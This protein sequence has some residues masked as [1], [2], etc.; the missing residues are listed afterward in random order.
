MK[1]EDTNNAKLEWLTEM[2]NLFLS[3][4]KK[5]FTDVDKILVSTFGVKS[6]CREKVILDLD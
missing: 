5:N 2:D 6:F 1:V 4:K 3:S